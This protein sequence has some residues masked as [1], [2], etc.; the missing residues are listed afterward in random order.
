MSFT[1]SFSSFLGILGKS[2][3]IALDIGTDS[4]KM[5][6]M[7]RS[8]SNIGISAC[9]RW[10]F[11]EGLGQK[12]Q[13]AGEQSKSCSAQRRQLTVAAIKDMLH[14]GGFRGRRVNV[15]LPTGRL[16][17]MNIRLPHMAPA[18]LEQAVRWE[19][20]E[21]FNFE[22]MPDQVAFLNAGQVRAG[23]DIKDEIIMLAAGQ[24]VVTEHLEL[25]E[26]VGL[27]PE[28]VDAEPVALFRGFERFLRRRADEQAVSVIVD[29]GLSATRVVIARG[30]GIVLIKCIDIGGRK[31][32][33]A[34]A[35]RFNLSYEEAADL[36]MRV[37]KEHAERNGEEAGPEAA[38]PVQAQDASGSCGA[39]G[40]QEDA[41]MA[42]PPVS[43]QHGSLEWTI[44][45][46]V[47]AEV[48]VLAQE[49]SL[50]LRY[51]SVTFRGLRPQKVTLTGGEAYDPA[52]LGIFKEQLNIE[53]VVGRPLR[54]VDVSGVFFEKSLGA[55]RR[56]MLSEWAVCT[57][58][59]YGSIELPVVERETP[60]VLGMSA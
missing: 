24:D 30:R 37:M 31:L 40:A 56:G 12:S 2:L 19:A 48:E 34:V 59:S 10:R 8:G 15:S 41:S 47:R 27:K 4:I 45:D 54:G 58:L 9:G 20:K 22:L 50:C 21:R 35:K 49:V 39:S 6:Q 5:L 36:R 23:N 43:G 17:I 53:C 7:C 38:E 14:T 18:E 28:H 16:G 46:A 1:K 13:T 32:I 29:V 33:E 57:G 60:E 3:P 55:N 26:Q 25:L 51:C 44:R 52:I 11:P 42:P